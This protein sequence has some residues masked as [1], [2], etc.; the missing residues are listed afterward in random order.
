LLLNDCEYH[1]VQPTDYSVNNV[2][3]WRLV[4]VWYTGRS[5]S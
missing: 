3:I 1:H 2:S 4:R 5:G